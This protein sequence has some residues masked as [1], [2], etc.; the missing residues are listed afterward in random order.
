[1]LLDHAKYLWI[2]QIKWP[3]GPGV[4]PGWQ[5]DIATGTTENFKFSCEWQ[6]PATLKLPTL[7]LLKL[8]CQW[9]CHCQHT[10]R[11]AQN[12]KILSVQCTSSLGQ[13]T[14]SL[15]HF[16]FLLRLTFWFSLVWSGLKIKKAS[17]ATWTKKSES[18]TWSHSL[19]LTLQFEWQMQDPITAGRVPPWDCAAADATANLSWLWISA[20][21]TLIW[22]A[23]CRQQ[24]N[25]E[26]GASQGQ[27]SCRAG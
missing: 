12:L 6:T 21:T 3:R 14:K 13:I 2:V 26:P 23:G 22:A 16:H 24:G 27:L 8:I 9:V 15:F 20:N 18:L 10:K 17:C 11:N 4:L 5:A 19:R 7:N 25:A 1:M